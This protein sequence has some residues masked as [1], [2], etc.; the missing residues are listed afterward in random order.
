MPLYQYELAEGECKV[1]RGTFEL[2]R[3]LDAPELTACPLCKKAVRKCPAQ[4][5]SPKVLRKPSTSEAKSAGFKV[6][7]KVDSGTYERQ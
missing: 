7:K 5:Y 6:Y 3:P 1:C 4:V 2:R